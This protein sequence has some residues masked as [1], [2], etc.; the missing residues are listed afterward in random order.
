M[1]GDG[2]GWASDPLQNEANIGYRILVKAIPQMNSNKR[3]FE[4]THAR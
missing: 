1:M 3:L 2:N 4:E